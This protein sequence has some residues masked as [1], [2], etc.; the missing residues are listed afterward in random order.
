MH[1]D[2][3]SVAKATRFELTEIIIPLLTFYN[4]PMVT[5]PLDAFTPRLRDDFGIRRGDPMDPPWWLAVSDALRRANDD[6]DGAPVAWRDPAGAAAAAGAEA[7]ADHRE[8][9]RGRREEPRRSNVPELFFAT[10]PG[11]CSDGD[12]YRCR[13]C[14]VCSNRR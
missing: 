13:R 6:D 5:S 3:I 11:C 7:G 14:L 1:R 8:N 9:R 10:R 4:H 2:I 12:H